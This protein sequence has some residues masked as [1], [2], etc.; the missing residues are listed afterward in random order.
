MKVKKV[1]VLFQI[2]FLFI[3]NISQIKTEF[4]TFQTNIL[5]NIFQFTNKKLESITQYDYKKGKICISPLSMYQI[6]SLVSNGAKEKTQLEILETLTSKKNI[7]S[8]IQINLNLNNENILK[9]YEN[10]K[11]ISIANAILS[12]IPITE[13][14]GLISKRYKAFYSILESANQVNSWC[15]KQTNGKIKKIIENINGI[16]LILLNAVYF[17]YD[18]KFPFEKESTYVNNFYN[19]NQTITKVEMMS[20]KFH[21]I[22]YFQNENLQMIELPYKDDNISMIIILPLKDKF[23]SIFDYLNQEKNDITKLINN[24]QPR[25]N[26]IILKLPKFEFEYEVSLKDSLLN[27]NMKE[28]FSNNADFSKITKEKNLK[29][30]DIIQKT[31]IKVD[32]LGTEAAAVTGIMMVESAALIE[33]IIHMNVDHSF[34]FM[35]RDKRIKDVNGDELMMFIGCVDNL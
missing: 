8:N 33:N 34:I 30:D 15:E 13:E 31:Y 25:D 2:I 24:L 22:N 17:K 28:A 14:F 21:S 32:E 11:N 29:I 27:I 9:T 12:K 10:N 5:N 7:N 16:E 1:R 35:V 3:Y 6:I 20:K 23:H 18:W 26:V 4:Q 19:E